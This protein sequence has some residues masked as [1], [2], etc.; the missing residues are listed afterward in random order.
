MKMYLCRW[1][2]GDFSAVHATSKQ[3]AIFLL[4]DVGAA[5]WKDVFAVESFMVH[6]RLRFPSDVDQRYPDFEVDDFG[7]ENFEDIRGMYPELEEVREQIEQIYADSPEPSHDQLDEIRQLVA[8]AFD[9]E[10]GNRAA[11][12]SKR[13]KI[14]SESA[15]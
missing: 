7:E 2:N 5:K 3:E 10:C 6:F 12:K 9:R 4:D 13:P 8:L 11:S 14:S 15:E 1:P